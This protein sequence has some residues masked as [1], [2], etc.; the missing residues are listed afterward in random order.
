VLFSISKIKDQRSKIK[1]QR[2]KIKNQNKSQIRIADNYHTRDI[3]F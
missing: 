3:V 2:S 1:D